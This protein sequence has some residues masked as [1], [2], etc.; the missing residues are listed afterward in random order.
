MKPADAYK[1]LKAAAKAKPGAW[2][3]HPWGETVYKVGKKVFVFMGVDKADGGFGLSCK[4]PNSSEAAI[5]MFSWASPTGYGLGKSGWVSAQFE[6]KDDVPVDLLL[7]WIDESYQ[8]IAPAKLL[9]E[10]APKAKPKARKKPA[11]TR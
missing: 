1:K 6:K 7:Q 4:L 10:P 5:T 2:E 8:S 9:K 3:D 11:K